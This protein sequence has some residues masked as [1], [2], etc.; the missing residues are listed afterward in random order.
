MNARRATSLLLL[1]LTPS[2]ALLGKSD[3]ITPRY[4]SPEGARAMRPTPPAESGLELRLGRVSSDAF[5]RDRMIH[6]DSAYELGYYDERAW[7][8]KPEMYVRRAVE[9]ELF[10]DQGIQRVV[11]GAATTLDVDLVAFEEV[12]GPAHVGRVELAFVLYDDR[13]VRV[14]RTIVVDRPIA[15]AKGDALAPAVVS[16]IGDALAA[17]VDAIASTVVTELRSES[18]AAKASAAAASASSTGARVHAPE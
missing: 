7:T 5:I 3:P 2:C 9:R 1:G 4:F 8:E 16:A 18:Q 12:R 6:R 10:D 11:S 15:D 17:A 13:T 14:S